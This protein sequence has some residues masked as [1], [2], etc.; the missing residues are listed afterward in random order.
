M[1]S[2]R[3]CLTCKASLCECP[4]LWTTNLANAQG[5]C[6]LC[7]LGAKCLLAARVEIEEARGKRV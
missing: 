6:K 7:A 3:T 4:G 5:I 1:K 2:K